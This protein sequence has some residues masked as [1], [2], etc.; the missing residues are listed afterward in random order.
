MTSEKMAA[1][2]FG[3][4]N[5]WDPNIYNRFSSEREAPFWDL[6]N[7]LEPVP[8]GRVADL[9][10]GDGRLT[11]ALHLRLNAGHTLGID[12][13]P[14]M[15]VETT[16]HASDSVSFAKGDI[17]SWIAPAPFDVIFANASLQWVADHPRVIASLRGSLAPQGQLAVQVPSNADH[18]VYQL[19]NQLGRE[20]LGDD[21]PMD[22]VA[23]NV[24]KPEDYSVLLESLGFS[25][26]HV[27]LVVY[28]H[29]L[30]SAAETVEW[31]KGTSLNRFK[32]VFD[33]GGYK[34]F[35]EQY[36]QLVIRELGDKSPYFFTF[37]IILMWARL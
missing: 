29:H 18:V 20:W 13:A 4:E 19:A 30:S 7:L 35:L 9:G 36:R 8:D 31:V 24:L 22:T 28:G 10:C 26:Q 16:A 23:K 25:R 2:A 21:S 12:S 1:A 17:A 6:A 15:L 14:G 5:A 32:A 33:E 34:E 37:N 27:R 11:A 3:R